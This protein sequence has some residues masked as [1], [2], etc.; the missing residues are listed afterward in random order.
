MPS[1]KTAFRDYL[2]ADVTIASFVSTRVYPFAAPP[3]ATLPYILYSR[4]SADHGHHYGGADGLTRQRLDVDSYGTDA[5]TVESMADAIRERCDGFKGLMGTDNLDVRGLWLDDDDDRL[6]L[7]NT[8]S[9]VVTHR[10]R[11][12][13]FIWFVESVPTFP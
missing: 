4:I 5:L 7:P 1:L 11:Q 6:T 2:V 13:L 10:V 12:D 8:G 3:E 9:E